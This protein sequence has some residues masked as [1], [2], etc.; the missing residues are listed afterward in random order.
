MGGLRF[1]VCEVHMSQAFH[2]DQKNFNRPIGF[3]D[4]WFLGLAEYV[5]SG[6]KDPSTKVGAVIVDKHR[7]V[8][9]MGYNGFARGVDDLPERYEDRETKYK[10]I[11]HAELNAIL[12]ADKPLQGCTIYVWPTLMIPAVCPECCKAVIQ[13]GIKEV[14]C[15]QAPTSPRWQ[16]MAE[17]SR[18]ML[19]EA[20]VRM[21]TIKSDT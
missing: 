11:V 18:S 20:R 19:C 2:S 16:A 13:A 10:F 7:I 1:L 14:V 9:G 3:W 6:S 8:R 12:N 15:W 5:A 17:I 21:R 4:S